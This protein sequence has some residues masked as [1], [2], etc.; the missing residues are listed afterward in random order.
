MGS[1]PTVPGWLRADWKQRGVRLTTAYQAD[2]KAAH[3]RKERREVWVLWDP[4]VAAYAG[5]A[6]TVGKPWPHLQQIYWIRRERTIKG[7]TTVEVGYGITSLGPREAKAGRILKWVREYWGIEN[8]LHWVR[9]V[10]LDEDRS[11]VRSG[12]APQVCAGL[13]NLGIA[14][15]RRIGTTNIAAKLRTFSARPRAAVDLVL[16][17]GSG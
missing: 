1:P 12:A 16:S 11:Q 6:G 5:S 7:K 13:R 10:T 4:E 9:D 3:G 2:A 8:R 17:A 14:L 15:L